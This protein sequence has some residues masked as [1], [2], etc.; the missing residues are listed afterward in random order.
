MSEQHALP[1]IAFGLVVWDL[2]KEILLDQIFHE[3]NNILNCFYNA[4]LLEGQVFWTQHIATI[5][6]TEL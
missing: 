3:R 2:W 6:D 5:R 1:A 4:R